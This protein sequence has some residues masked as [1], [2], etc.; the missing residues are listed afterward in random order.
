MWIDS[1]VIWR[2]STLRY[3]RGGGVCCSFSPSLLQSHSRRMPQSL[4]RCLRFWAGC[5]L[6]LNPGRESSVTDCTVRV[7]DG[8]CPR[9]HSCRIVSLDTLSHRRQA[10]AALESL[11]LCQRKD[12]ERR[13]E[14]STQ[15][16][17]CSLCV[18]VLPFPPELPSSWFCV[19]TFLCLWPWPCR[20]LTWWPKALSQT[21]PG[22]WNTVFLLKWDDISP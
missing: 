3:F 16:G 8:S 9:A 20:E 10:L 15:G 5:V 6:T 22:P 4:G 1:A 14:P 17:S 13:E 7:R 21:L 12:E 11:G 19:A 18:Y 2:G